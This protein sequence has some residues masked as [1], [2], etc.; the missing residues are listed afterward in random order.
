MIF[1]YACFKG[2]RYGVWYVLCILIALYLC[3]PAVQADS[4][5]SHLLLPITID[6]GVIFG[7]GLDEMTGGYD[8][9]TLLRFFPFMRGRGAGAR[10]LE[11][12]NV[13]PAGANDPGNGGGE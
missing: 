11:M 6:F 12:G 4:T 9:N 10:D 13:N 7:I 5:T 8:L 1:I 3:G 2:P